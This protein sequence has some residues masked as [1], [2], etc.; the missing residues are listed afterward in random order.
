MLSYV[1]RRLSQSVLVLFGVATIVFFLVRLSG[2]PAKIMLPPNAS[3]DQ[4]AT[5]RHQ[6]GLDQPLIL[7]YLDYLWR[8]VHL[9]LGRSLFFHQPSVDI[10]AER[11]PATLQL[12]GAAMLFALLLAL[13]AGVFAALRRGKASD[14]AISG[15]VLLG[16]STPAFWVGILLILVF[17]VKLGLFPTSG[18]GGL[19]HLVLPAVCLSLY[20]MA[21]VSRL[22]RSS[23]IDVLGEDFIRAARAK[24]LS[25][26]AVLLGHAM[27]NAALPVITVTALELA[28]LLGG[29]IVTEKVFAWPGLGRLT[30]ESINN[31]DF[32]MVQAVIL[33][34][35]VIFVVVNLVVDLCYGLLDP[36]IRLSDS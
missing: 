9:D 1:L 25:K 33:T 19:S 3:L 6:L 29:A 8:L 26:R 18:Y 31:R 14:S 15:A 20:S 24:G 11:L 12:A 16:Q 30:V 17:A 2:D 22:L 21:I 28:G 36:R 34:F 10:I 13:P 23:L 4:V 7:Q 27:R 35:A 32:P 5:L